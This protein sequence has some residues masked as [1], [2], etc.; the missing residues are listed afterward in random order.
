MRSFIA[1]SI[2]FCILLS[3]EKEDQKVRVLIFSKTSG[4]RHESIGVGKLAILELAKKNNFEADTTE[5]ASYFN[6]NNLKQYR[7]VVFLNTTQDVLD[8]YQQADFERFIQAGGGYVGIHA[9]ADTEY[10]WSWY[11]ELTGAYF[12]SHP[13]IQ[14]A[15]FIKKENSELSNGLPDEWT[16]T[17]E[18]Y[19]Y[20][21]ISDKIKV[22]YTLDESSYSGG[23][24]GD[25]HPIAWYHEFDGG[26]AFY[27][28]MGHTKE[29][30]EDS[31]F[32]LHISQG[33]QYAVG[34][35]PLD[36]SKARTMRVPEANRFNKVVLKYHFD[37]PTE[38]T[39]LPDNRIIFIERKGNVKLYDPKNDS[40]QIINTFKVWTKSEDGML[41]LT[42]DPNFS[43]NK[44]IYIYYSHPDKSVNVLS[45]FVFTGDKIDMASEKQMLEVAV[46]RETCCHTGGSLAFDT[47]GNLFISTGDNTSPFES[48]GYSPADERP[49]RSPFDAQKSSGNTNDLRGKIL[50]IHPEKDGSYTIPDGNLFP[51]GEEKTRPEI[52]VMG[53]RNPYRIS[54]DRKTNYL[55]WGEVGPDAGTNDSLRGP[56]GYDEV[57]QA[58]K[59]GY[60]GWPYF[61]GKN[62]A[63]G[64]YNFAT[65]ETGPRPDPNS[66][67]N[68]SPNNTGKIELPPVSPPFI[69][70]PYAK[71]DEFPLVKEGGRNAMA[72]PIYYSEDYK[73]LTTAYPS[74]FD[75]KLII[76]D[77]MRN[78]VMLVTMDAEGNY[79]SMEPFLQYTNFNNI[80]DMAVGPDG[81]LY[82][83]EYGSVW[84]KSNEDSRLSRID[85]NGGNRTP[86]VKLIADK[87]AGAI[88]LH[89]KLS[90][91][92]TT[93]PDGD[94]M[95]YSL[96][97]LGKT[98]S[99]SNGE[100]ELT[101]DKA[102]I[103]KPKLTVVDEKGSLA[104]SEI[105]I[106]AG[107][108]PPH[109]SISITGNS[110]FY[111]P[112]SQI[113][114]TVAVQD[115][116]DGSTADGKISDVQISF[117][118]LALGYDMTAIAQGHQ[119]P[120]HV[121]KALLAS[122]DCKACHSINQ[123]SAGPAYYDIAKKY[124]GK[125]DAIEVLT[126]KVIK[127]GSG[128]WGTI[129]M[130][131][132]PQL[133]KEDVA[134][135]VDYILSLKDEKKEKTL[136]LKGT[137]TTGKD[138]GGT[139]LFT[140]S[141]KDKG[142]SSMPA[143]SNS[144]T[145]ILKSPS[146]D[147]S[148]LTAIGTAQKI[149][150]TKALLDNIKDKSSAIYEDVDLTQVGK[151]KLVTA[152]QADRTVGGEMEVY[153]DGPQGKLLGK[154][155]FEKSPKTS[156]P[157][158][159]VIRTDKITLQQPIEGK[160][161]LYLLFV[162]PQGYDKNLFYFSTLT[163]EKR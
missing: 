49:G 11:G 134:Q 46:Q 126:S 100:F 1:I 48:S 117:D 31:L 34:T 97:C 43:E 78:W 99:S 2:L 24:N 98:Q 64:K 14:T 115:T 162:N 51:K 137:V 163:L 42:I 94:K 152:T 111:F 66:P 9:A 25:Y 136:P 38:M 113:D 71:S 114:Y 155:N 89:V 125:T 17:D 87:E 145:I 103:Y 130:S 68:H 60:F 23:E 76:Y 90:A 140:A 6:E 109:V 72:G 86:Q 127:G 50:R 69:W 53:N 36:Y 91:K 88:P 55:Y 129:E 77:W 120:E 26:R 18:L 45:R 93:D 56:R 16:R 121:G 32:L 156:G 105:T 30:Y 82:T 122:S 62:Y 20:K 108:D 85:Y 47:K 22:L 123:K 84:F 15:K 92:G 149:T 107:N 148:G 151:I 138:I 65:K 3:C 40:L 147:A 5:D 74:Y 161:D 28:G 133:K 73:G 39:I 81:R 58:R 157:M 80:I 12:K 118:Y 143:L 144:K 83:L 19:N 101:F 79:V 63:Y 21:K 44:W 4:Y 150:P 7:A 119:K 146:M 141:Y 160:H 128:V 132:H 96:E 37:E 70:Y 13:Q 27:T 124:S 33:L 35:A 104:T 131:A 52:Y 142:S 59:A 110:M 102:G 67:E 57:N 153:L 75:G 8:H 10:E 154:T 112:N 29:C 95:T 106:I 116:E 54:I 159:S 158:G 41:G 61:V 139:Y 135:M